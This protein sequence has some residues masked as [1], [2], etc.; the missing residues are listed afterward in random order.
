MATAT[1][2]PHALKNM[3]AVPSDDKTVKKL[4]RVCWFSV[5]D[6]PVSARRVRAK[7]RT[8]GLEEKL[9]TLPKNDG[10]KASDVFKRAVR[11]Q[12]ARHRANDGTVTETDVR[13]VDETPDEILYQVTRVVRDK[14]EQRI[15]Y[16]AGV[17]V[18][19]NKATDD[20]GGKPMTEV[21]GSVSR[22]EGLAILDAIDEMVEQLSETVTGSKVRTLVRDYLQDTTNEKDGV[23]GLSGINLRGKAGGVY[24][25]PEKY[26]EQ[27]E[28]LAEFLGELYAEPGV[29]FLY[30]LPMADARTEREIVRQQLKLESVA[31]IEEATARV[32]NLLRGD[33]DRAVRDDVKD[34]WRA[35]LSKL[36]RRAA[37]YE[38]VLG[39]EQT[40]VLAHIAVLDKQI[41]L[42]GL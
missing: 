38:Q 32:R 1:S 41:A 37:E 8:A 15:L 34:H 11:G 13:D 27:V 16:Q 20:W 28:G 40:D 6:R 5:P 12:V 30:S 33:R 3:V 21:D 24:F 9:R 23:Y 22:R 25:V 39:D 18:W 31:D 29:G 19:F 7:W 10:P 14:T 35:E 17:R 2:T 36:K 4:G 42:L 26:L